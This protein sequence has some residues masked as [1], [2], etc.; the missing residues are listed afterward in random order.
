MRQFALAALVGWILSRIVFHFTG[1]EPANWG[2][3]PLVWAQD[4]T[5][6]CLAYGVGFLL[7]R[8][9][10]HAGSANARS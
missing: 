8:Q 5:V 9:V 1:L 2:D 7:A 6:W 10:W 4:F 3:S